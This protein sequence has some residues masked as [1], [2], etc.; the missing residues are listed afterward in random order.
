MPMRTGRWVRFWKRRPAVN[1]GDV[2]D[3]V[4]P[5]MLRDLGW[6]AVMLQ[7][8][9]IR[10]RLL[11]WLEAGE[12]D[13][14]FGPEVITMFLGPNR[15]VEVARIHRSRVA[16]GAPLTDEMAPISQGLRP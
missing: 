16:W 6:A 14:V 11:D 5:Q 15:E 3:D 10:R 1:E 4:D 8:V 7:P 9:S 2:P 13:F 12:V